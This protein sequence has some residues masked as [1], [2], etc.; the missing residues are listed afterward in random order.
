M[1]ISLRNTAP[2]TK[3]AQGEVSKMVRQALE[4][5][6]AFNIE[7]KNIITASLTFSP[8]YE[9]RNNRRVLVGQTARQTITFSVN[10]IQ[11]DN[12]KVSQIIDRLVQINGIELNQ[13]DF[14]VK[15]NTEH[16]IQSRE[17]AFQKA[18]EK[19]EQ[20]SKLS[21]LKV[22]KVLS[23]SEEGSQQV[24]PGSNRVLLQSFDIMETA[25]EAGSTMLPSGELEITTRI[26]AV[27]LIE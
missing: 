13:M 21:G 2:T 3:S 9:Y 23:I 22:R 1:N 16:F 12:E 4:V 18:I 25:A 27:F 14:S 6:A 24:F 7:D 15:N 8:E 17:L 26:S 20:Y 10:D 11:N 5:L 19:A